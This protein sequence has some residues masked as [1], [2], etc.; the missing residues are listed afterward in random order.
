M[1]RL[2]SRPGVIALLALAALLGWTSPGP[3]GTGLA[4]LSLA[5]IPAIF[6]VPPGGRP[7]VGGVVVLM[8][9]AAAALGDLGDGWRAGAS[10]LVLAVAGSLTVIGGA[11][12]PG[13]SRRYGPR[14]GRSAA[15]LDAGAD[16]IEL[17][18]SLDRGED[19]TVPGDA[20][21]SDDR[22]TPTGNGAVD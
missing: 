21:G 14:S 6:A 16:S 13:M 20:P 17:W 7:W 12:W 8:G 18:R 5:T 4:V 2:V 11:S 3:A 22:E 1:K 9:G 10:V 15:G 19:P